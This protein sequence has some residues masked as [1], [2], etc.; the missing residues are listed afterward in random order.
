MW[1]RNREE[2]WVLL[3]RYELQDAKTEAGLEAL[4][5]RLKFKSSR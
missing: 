1:F 4:N 3:M 2:K 5:L